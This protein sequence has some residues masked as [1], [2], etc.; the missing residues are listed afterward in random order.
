[1]CGSP[2]VQGQLDYIVRSF[3]CPSNETTRDNPEHA[4][5]RLV[6]SGHAMNSEAGPAWG[7]TRVGSQP[8]KAFELLSRVPRSEPHLLSLLF[9]YGPLVGSAAPSGNHDRPFQ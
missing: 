4:R 1:M 3:L 2:W 7:P 6:C 8:L 9:L 5:D